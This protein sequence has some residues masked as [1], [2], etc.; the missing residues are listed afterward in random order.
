[1]KFS[2]MAPVC[3]GPVEVAVITTDRRFRWVRHKRFDAA[4][5]EGG[6]YDVYRD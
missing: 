2:H 6:L 4:I 1:M 5:E 3:G